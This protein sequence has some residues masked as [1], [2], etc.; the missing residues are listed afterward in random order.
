MTEIEL[1]QPAV[2]IGELMREALDKGKIEEMGAAF[3]LYREMEAVRREQLFNAAF[4]EFKKTCPP[5]IRRTVDEYIT[6]TRNGAR[7]ARK[8]AS[9]SDITATVDGPLHDLGFSYYWGDAHLT[10]D[11]CIVREFILAHES[12]HR[13]ST[14]SPP[15]PIEGG[16]AHK[17]IDPNRKA[18]SASPQQRVGVADTYAMRYSMIS[19]LGLT[20]CDEDD[21]GRMPRHAEVDA[22][23]ITEEQYQTLNDLCIACGDDMVPR[24]L[25]N[26][27]IEKLSDL[28]ADK[29]EY[30]V[31]HIQREI[32]KRGSR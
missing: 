24:V 19:G 6:I 9:L 7:R 8:Y 15:I 32:E 20:T 29:Y 2:D 26:Q 30:F 13:R 14:K 10:D 22:P 11:G 25:K 18:T 17:A 31:G 16:T 3:Q 1:A 4:T 27:K 28:I 5:I 21:D 12:G 23:K